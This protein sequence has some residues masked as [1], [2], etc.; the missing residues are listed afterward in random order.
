MKCYNAA[1]GGVEVVECKEGENVC[2]WF[3]RMKSGQEVAKGCTSSS[4]R[5]IKT[6][7]DKCKLSRN[8]PIKAIGKKVNLDFFGSPDP[9]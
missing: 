1:D 9:L 7:R 2:H 4:K 5:G 6:V 8:S 3:W